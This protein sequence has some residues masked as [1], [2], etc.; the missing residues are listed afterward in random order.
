M[1]LSSSSARGNTGASRP[2]LMVNFTHN[3]LGSVYTLCSPDTLEPLL[4]SPIQLPSCSHQDGCYDDQDLQVAGC[5]NGFIFISDKED[6]AGPEDL[7]PWSP[8]KSETKVLPPSLFYSDGSPRAVGF[9]FDSES[10]DYKIL[11]Q[12]S[13]PSCEITN[14]QG[15]LYW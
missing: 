6:I 5:C 8:A 7:I 12:V 1:V 10:I 11:R 2:Q 15:K 4:P 14:S 9:G 13:R 3:R